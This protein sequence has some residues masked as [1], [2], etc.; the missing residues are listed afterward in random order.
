LGE[1][2]IAVG[3]VQWDNPMWRIPSEAA[4]EVV[5]RDASVT[6][7]GK[8]DRSDTKTRLSCGLQRLYEPV[9]DEQP[10]RL[11]YLMKLLGQSLSR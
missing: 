4:F 2:V 7:D 8:P 1:I 6:A 10:D 3:W 11:G 5:A 9:T